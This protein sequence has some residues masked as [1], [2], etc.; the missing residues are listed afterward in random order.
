MPIRIIA[1]RIC[2]IL[3]ALVF[4]SGGNCSNS[5]QPAPHSAPS[6]ASSTATTGNANGGPGAPASTMSGNA[7]ILDNL[8]MDY[9]QRAGLPP[10]SA[11]DILAGVAQAQAD[12]MAASG[13]AG[14]VG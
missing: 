11:N 1:H 6:A 3:L 8:I 4:L 13:S 10:V 9:R 14:F 5:D 2:L 7:S 12:D